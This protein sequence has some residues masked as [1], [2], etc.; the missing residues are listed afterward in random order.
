MLR[1]YPYPFGG[2]AYTLHLVWV[3]QRESDQGVD[4]HMTYDVQYEY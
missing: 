3:E 4:E 1:L 2:G